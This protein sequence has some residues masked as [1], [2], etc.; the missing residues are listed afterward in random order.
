MLI[1]TDLL[2][3][4]Q[5]N[6]L[7]KSVFQVIENLLFWNILGL[8]S[9]KTSRDVL[10]EILTISHLLEVNMTHFRLITA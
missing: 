7:Q 9:P 8:K 5:S 4:N 1:D 10:D 2:P 3:L 6:K